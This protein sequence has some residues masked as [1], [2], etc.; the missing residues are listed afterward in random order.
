MF[1]LLIAVI[2]LFIAG[3]THN[4]DIDRI[5]LPEGPF[6]TNE[7]AWIKRPGNNTVSGQAFIRQTGGGV[8]TCAGEEVSLTPVSSYATRRI[9]AI[10]GN[11]TRGYNHYG[12]N[13]TDYSDPDVDPKYFEYRLR[14]VCDA[15]G[16]FS[17]SRV[18]SGDYFLTTRVWWQVG[19]FTQGGNLM[20]RLSLSG[21]Q[22]KR[23]LM[24]P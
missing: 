7:V 16:N 20:R 15:A 8:V 19:N 10:Y 9:Q 5:E 4:I 1:R 17:F 18:P 21:G 13:R 23:I 11:T 14:S 2:A 22:E 12:Y 6:D 24:S 3:C